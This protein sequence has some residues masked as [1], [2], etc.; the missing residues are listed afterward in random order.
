MLS[1][2]G[3]PLC[4]LHGPFCCGG[5]TTV[6]SL[7]GGAGS[8]ANWLQSP[9]SCSTCCPF[10]WVG[11]GP[12]MTLYVAMGIPGLVPACRLAGKAPGVSRLERGDQKGACQHCRVPI[13][14]QIIAATL[15]KGQHLVASFLSGTLSKWASGSHPESF[16]ITT[17]VPGTYS[18]WDSAYP[19]RAVS[20][21]LSL[22][23][24]PIWPSSQM[25][26]GLV[27]FVNKSQAGELMWTLDHLL[28]EKPSAII[29]LF[30]SCFSG[31]GSL[32]ILTSPALPLS[33]LRFFLYIFR[34]KP[35]LLVFRSF[36]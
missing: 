13:L 8:P 4:G 23:V 25:I 17:P 10:L 22:P 15:F 33:S 32:T 27:F 2:L 11:L 31:S 34:W 20:I 1:G 14:P 30:V 26:L 28:L 36:S 5:L 29:L 19:V 7:T 21:S 12:G 18:V 16:Q 6:R 3:V 24:L 9:Y 35:F